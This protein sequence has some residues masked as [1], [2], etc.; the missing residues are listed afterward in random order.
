MLRE[1]GGAGHVAYPLV[2][3]TVNIGSRLESLAPAGG[4]LIGARTYVQLPAGTVVA[5][6]LGLRVKGK[7]D[8]VNAF[9]LLALP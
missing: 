5:P 7:E 1:V 6:R 8:P 4:V 2:G 9:L 3:D